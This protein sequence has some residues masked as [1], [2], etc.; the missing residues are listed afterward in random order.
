MVKVTLWRQDTEIRFPVRS[1]GQ[2]HA[3]RSRLFLGVEH[4]GVIGYGE[5]APQPHELNGDAAIADVIDEVRIFVLAQ[6][7]QILEREGDL[8]SW[9]RVARFAGSRAASNPAVALLEMALLD[10]ELR[11]A[12]SLIDSLWPVRFDTPLQSTVS[13]IDDGE[14]HVD[15]GAARVRAKISAAAITSAALGRLGELSTPVLLDYN[16]G[17]SSD[18]DVI[19]QLRVI[20]DVVDVVGVEQPYAV[21]NVVDTARLAERLDVAVSVDEG[22]RSVRD[23]AQIVRYQAAE[24]ICVKPARVGGLANARTIIVAAQEAG[25]R[26]YVGGFFESPYARSVHRALARSCVEEPSDLGPVDVVNDGYSREVDTVERG[27]GVTP[28]A[29]MLERGAVLVDAEVTT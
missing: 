29:E 8:P 4:D 3:E 6:L 21:G 10:R 7:Q 20:R 25:L 9:T 16:C 15:A 28:S 13:L 22:V 1:A 11:V 24:I 26:P 23:V 2:H 18:A 5:V 17:A 14:W 27:F 12:G 19:E